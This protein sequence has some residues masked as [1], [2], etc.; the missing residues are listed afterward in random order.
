MVSGD[1]ILDAGQP[2]RCGEG[3]GGGLGLKLPGPNEGGWLV[4]VA[5]LKVAPNKKIFGQIFLS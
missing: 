2:I 3:E 4:H 1:V 5:R